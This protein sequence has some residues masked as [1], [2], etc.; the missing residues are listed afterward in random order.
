MSWWL[1]V[2]GDRGGGGGRG[3]VTVLKAGL[4]TASSRF[5]R[6]TLGSG[7][8]M[9]SFWSAGLGL[10]HSPVPLLGYWPRGL[11][12]L[13]LPL[14]GQLHGPDACVVYVGQSERNTPLAVRPQGSGRPGPGAPTQYEQQPSAVRKPSQ[15]RPCVGREG[16]HLATFLNSY[17]SWT[18]GKIIGS[19]ALRVPG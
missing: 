14:Q 10:V 12:M 6:L 17:F 2:A 18:D 16:S 3:K 9:A 5:T 13:L 15:V 4:W 11:Y 19:L 1:R 7:F 8:A